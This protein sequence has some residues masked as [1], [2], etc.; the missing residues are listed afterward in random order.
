[1]AAVEPDLSQ[2][3]PSDIPEA[4][5]DGIDNEASRNGFTVASSGFAAMK[6][7]QVGEELQKR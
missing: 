4:P 1:M 2:I 7:F 3:P 6:L 5:Q